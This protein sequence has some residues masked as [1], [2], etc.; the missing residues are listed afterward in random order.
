MRMREQEESTDK[1]GEDQRI[2]ALPIDEVRSS[3]EEAAA[4]RRK[5]LCHAKA[6]SLQ[7]GTL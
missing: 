1:S 7:L 4:D 3:K 6:P 5:Q 2:S